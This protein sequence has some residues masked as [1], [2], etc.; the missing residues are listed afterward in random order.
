[1]TLSWINIIPKIRI[2]ILCLA[3]LAYGQPMT[4]MAHQNMGA[5]MISDLQ[6]TAS[7]CDQAM[8]DQDGNKPASIGCCDAGD[9]DH[10]CAGMS[11]TLPP[12][13]ASIRPGAKQ[14]H[15]NAFLSHPIAADLS[16]AT[17]PPQV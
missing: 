16:R 8:M 7:H 9:C 5:D 12:L 10:P 4:V 14:S 15:K 11:V 13:T 3:L 1:M 2:A 17:P 6:N